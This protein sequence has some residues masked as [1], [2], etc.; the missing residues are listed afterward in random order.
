MLLENV[1]SREVLNYLEVFSDVEYSSPLFDGTVKRIND[2]SRRSVFC[3]FPEAEYDPALCV[4]AWHGV[5]HWLR[6]NDEP[7]ITPLLNDSAKEYWPIITELEQNV[8]LGEIYKLVKNQWPETDD[9]WFALD[10]NVPMCLEA[11]NHYHVIRLV[12]VDIQA[13]DRAEFEII[14]TKDGW[15]VDCAVG[16]F[17]AA[18][19]NRL[20][21]VW[22]E[23]IE[24]IKLTPNTSLSSQ[25]YSNDSDADWEVTGPNFPLSGNL[26]KQ[27]LQQVE[28]TPDVIAV[29]DENSELTYQ[30]LNQRSS[31]WAQ[32]LIQSGVKLGTPVGVSFQRNHKM[33][34]AQLAVL[35]A[36]G[37][38]IPMDSDQPKTR[39]ENII[40]DAELSLILSEKFYAES[41]ASKLPQTELLICEQ[42]PCVSV[43]DVT[44]AAVEQLTIEDLAYVIFTSGSTG[45][46]KGVKISHGNLLN[47]VS[48]I[49]RCYVNGDDVFCQFAPFTFDASVAEIHSGIMNGVPLC[50]F[51]KAQIDNPQKLQAYMTEQKVTFAA[52]PP[53]YA[54][55]LSPSELPRLRTL[56][57]AGSAPD[58]ELV[59]RWCPHV[60]YINA[61]GPTETTILST[62]W[63]VKHLPDEGEP[64]VIGSPIINTDLRV[65]N[66]FG[67]VLPEGM[68]GELQIGGAGV[69]KGTIL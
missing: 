68:L 44:F 62:A 61:Y 60:N 27:F 10:S 57:T 13:Q 25:A 33:V 28:K 50:I 12:D 24:A 9:H 35:K 7:V 32:S 36:G 8:T 23:F 19:Q 2:T 15:V 22:R 59:Q 65:V 14:Y 21:V 66:R 56:L 54:K 17:T 64:I 52:F 39:L 67:H 1:R 5:L 42:I 20:C 37:V 46:P 16:S 51:S 53:Q 55:H 29:K 40:E 3:H 6:Y 43:D 63:D 31:E 11:Q 38:F 30:Q 47:F 18:Y 41:L 48:H 49:E 69:S 26:V 34:I 58:I 4:A 45:R